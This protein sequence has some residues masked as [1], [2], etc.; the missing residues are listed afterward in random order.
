MLQ[1]DLSCE[2]NLHVA[3]MSLRGSGPIIIQME[4]TGQ[5]CI[6]V[7]VLSHI[8]VSLCKILIIFFQIVQN[9]NHFLSDFVK[10]KTFSGQMIQPSNSNKNV[11]IK[12]S[13][14]DTFLE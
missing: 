4:T 9:L 7:I 2:G 1:D 11:E 3:F 5:V 10:F 12:F 13:A 8:S 6:H 14:H